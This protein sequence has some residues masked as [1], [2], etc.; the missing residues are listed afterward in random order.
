MAEITHPAQAIDRLVTG[1]EQRRLALIL[2]PGLPHGAPSE[3]ELAKTLEAEL[4]FEE[5]SPTDGWLR[6]RLP[7]DPVV[8][9]GVAASAFAR[10]FSSKQS[11]GLAALQRRIVAEIVGRKLRPNA[12]HAAVAELARGSLRAV[13]SLGWDGL[14]HEVLEAQGIRYAGPCDPPPTAGPPLVELIEP[15]G[16]VRAPETLAITTAQRCHAV[17]PRGSAGADM[18]RVFETCDVLLLGVEP[19]EPAVAAFSPLGRE[20]GRTMVCLNLDAEP[21]LVQAWQEQGFFPAKV[22]TQR[23]S[24]LAT[25]I[26]RFVRLLSG[27]SRPATWSKAGAIV[28]LDP[29]RLLEIA[30]ILQSVSSAAKK[31]LDDFVAAMSLEVDPAWRWKDFVEAVHAGISPV[32]E[33]RTAV[34]RLVHLVRDKVPG[35]TQL[36]KL[37][38]E[39]QSERALGRPTEKG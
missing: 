18:A 30:E 15:Y 11:A 16:S 21:M 24:D 33:G 10:R 14:M 36:R 31:P 39:L 6:P 37:D 28:S 2:G 5:S 7:L 1:Y 13:V 17:G 25:V 3:A 23:S 34:A 22:F 32:G 4:G 29:A 8:R 9:L 35:S 12:V 27:S 26:A 19:H 38:G 20:Q